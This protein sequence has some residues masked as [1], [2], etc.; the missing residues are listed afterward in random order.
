MRTG[1]PI[2]DLTHGRPKVRAIWGT[3]RIPYQPLVYIAR[4]DNTYPAAG[5]SIIFIT[6]EEFPVQQGDYVYIGHEHGSSKTAHQVTAVANASG[7]VTIEAAGVTSIPLDTVVFGFSQQFAACHAHDSFVTH[8]A[9]GIPCITEPHGVRAPPSI[10]HA[11]VQRK[12]RAI[13]SYNENV[14]EIEW[15]LTTVAGT[16]SLRNLTELETSA[17]DASRIDAATGHIQIAPG[18]DGGIV[19]GAGVGNTIVCSDMAPHI[20]ASAHYEG[21]GGQDMAHADN[22]KSLLPSHYFQVDATETTGDYSD[23]TFHDFITSHVD[24]DWTV[25]IVNAPG[26]QKRLTAKANLPN[27]AGNQQLIVEGNSDYV[28]QSQVA[29]KPYRFCGQLEMPTRNGLGNNAVQNPTLKYIL[30]TNNRSSVPGYFGGNGNMAATEQFDVARTRRPWG[31]R[32]IFKVP[33]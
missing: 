29:N 2:W 31:L 27:N 21:H 9:A 23:P 17:P 8:L 3:R 30:F 32:G 26:A 28:V 4:T 5:G 10:N 7:Q 18:P 33:A 19:R 6:N 25:D 20:G 14:S 1:L 24:E 12:I 16:N 13:Q 15:D 22:N 11:R